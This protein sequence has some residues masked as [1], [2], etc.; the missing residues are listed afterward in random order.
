M[1]SKGTYHD[2]GGNECRSCSRGQYQPI[3]GQ[4]ACLGCPAGTST[5]E[6]ASIDANQCVG[7]KTIP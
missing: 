4:I 2:V 6:F 7:K 3:S 1:C 5:P